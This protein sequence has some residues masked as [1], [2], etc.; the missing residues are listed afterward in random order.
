MNAVW[1]QD[2]FGRAAARPRTTPRIEAVHVRGTSDAVLNS[3][4]QKAQLALA[5][6]ER[7]LADRPTNRQLNN[8]EAM[9]RRDGVRR[10]IVERLEAP[11][12]DSTS[13]APRS[14]EL[15]SEVYGLNANPVPR[16]PRASGKD[17]VRPS[18]TAVFSSAPA[19]ERVEGRK[20]WPSALPHAVEELGVP[21]VLMSRARPATVAT[22]MPVNRAHAPTPAPALVAPR[23]PLTPKRGA[24]ADRQSNLSASLAKAV[25]GTMNEVNEARG[26]ERCQSARTNAPSALKTAPRPDGVRKA[27]SDPKAI[28]KLSESSPEL[29]RQPP[30]QQP[31]LPSAPAAPKSTVPP[32]PL[33]QQQPQQQPLKQV[34]AAGQDP[35]SAD[36]A[37]APEAGG[38]P[39]GAPAAASPLRSH[40]QGHLLGALHV[41]SKTSGTSLS[42]TSGSGLPKDELRDLGYSRLGPI[43]AGAFST[44]IRARDQSS[45]RE[46]AIKTYAMRARGGRAPGVAPEAVMAEIACLQVLQ[47]AAH[48][49]IAQLL[50]VH[51]TSD[52]SSINLVLSLCDG[53]SVLRQL[54]K[55]GPRRGM[56]EVLAAPLLLQVAGALAHIHGLGVTHRDVKPANLVFTSQLRDRIQ[57]VDFGFA[58]IHQPADATSARRLHT[59]CGTPSYLAPELVRA[60]G[61]NSGVRSSKAGYWGPPVDVWALGV[62]AF[63]LFHNR[64]PFRAESIPQ[65]Y[66]R[67]LKGAH[68]DH[69]HW[70]PS[71]SSKGRSIVRRL[72]SLDVAER[73]TASDAAR[74]CEAY[75]DMLDGSAAANGGQAMSQAGD[76]GGL[77]WDVVDE[78]RAMLQ[79]RSGSRGCN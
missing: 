71:L 67:I 50:A 18:G 68:D 59:L 60:G 14:M 52:G 76:G 32:P 73:P 72:L 13:K 42:A 62:L 75:V 16:R 48:Q 30:Q 39:S 51:R 21:R 35:A 28:R 22:A 24:V 29:L 25:Q 1:P 41:V 40:L 15:I 61:V 78:I 46:V 79:E 53:G 6:A 7:C 45:Q 19:A 27:I 10:G 20:A 47:P 66:A 70:D 36:V 43:A 5:A 4:L 64:Q 33:P 11:S 8:I 54:Q 17:L 38:P 63:E 55:L 65:L 56:A 12:E 57:I 77:P 49:G 26:E 34:P 9:R 44:I 2:P 69:L 74:V 3:V 23:P 58:A 31:P 37:P